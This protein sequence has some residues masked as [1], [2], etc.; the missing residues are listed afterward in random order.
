MKRKLSEESNDFADLQSV[1]A[2]VSKFEVDDD[3][4]DL[5]GLTDDFIDINEPKVEVEVD[6][7]DDDG[8][9][10]LDKTDD[11]MECQGTTEDPL[12]HM[13]IADETKESPPGTPKILNDAEQDF[14]QV[15][16]LIS[17]LV[18]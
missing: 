15:T 18:I 9:E 13:G 12:D 7:I 3:E 10:I 14:A 6:K 17:F 1:P 4:T 2:V 5:L 8:K 16:K 11:F